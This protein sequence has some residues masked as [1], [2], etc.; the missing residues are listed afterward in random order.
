MN[1]V[2]KIMK[3]QLMNYEGWPAPKEVN[4]ENETRYL[5]QRNRWNSCYSLCNRYYL[6]GDALN[7]FK[8]VI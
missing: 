5:E 8:H 2:F 7:A 4:Q 3:T 6:V 1:D